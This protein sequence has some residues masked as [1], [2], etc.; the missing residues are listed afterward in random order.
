VNLRDLECFFA[1]ADEL[2]FGRAAE[3]LY[4]AQSTLSVAIRRLESE[5]GAQLFTRSTRRVELTPI[6]ELFY[7]ESLSAYHQLESAFSSAR[8]TGRTSIQ[9]QVA[10]DA[11]CRR[12][13]APLLAQM[14]TRSPNALLIFH[15]L[16][17]PE[18]SAALHRRAIDL[19][20]CWAPTVDPDIASTTLSSAGFI[21]ILRESDPLAAGKVTLERLAGE[22]LIGPSRQNN[23]S[24][25]DSF[26][27]TMDSLAIPWSLVATADRI[28]NVASRVLAGQ[29]VGIVLAPSAK[30][31][32]IAGVKY[33][34]ITN[35]GSLIEQALI[36]RKADPP[37]ALKDLFTESLAEVISQ[38]SALS[39]S[40]GRPE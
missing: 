34:T 14:H 17:A 15:E 8:S 3:R 18:Q 9:L 11:D 29:G 33:V 22:P 21:A 35:E 38:D 27:A 5:V 39:Y 40:K 28:E 16:T 2:H 4:L 31:H 7:K 37:S 32:V 12:Y 25:F 19:G 36:W 24:L 13:E 30:H 23:P 20:V 1:T 6:G 26:A 10:F